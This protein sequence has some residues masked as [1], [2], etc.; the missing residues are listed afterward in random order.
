MK[1]AMLMVALLLA[2]AEQPMDLVQARL[3]RGDA[4][5]AREALAQVAEP[6]GTD[7]AAR[8]AWLDANARIAW[9]AGE[10]DRAFALGV[11]AQVLAER[12][13]VE[14][15]ALTAAFTPQRAWVDPGCGVALR[16][17]P[18]GDAGAQGGA[19][20]AA[21]LALPE[22]K[23]AGGSW[24]VCAA[25]LL[26]GSTPMPAIEKLK[27]GRETPAQSRAR[28]RV[29]L[30]RLACEARAGEAK[31]AERTLKELRELAKQSRQATPFMQWFEGELLLR[32]TAKRDPRLASLRFTQSAAAFDEAP[33]LRVAALKRAAEALNEIDPQE[34]ARLRAAADKEIP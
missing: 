21:L 17:L 25:R 15:A 29:A 34:A 5:G 4:A 19:L 2:A 10:M 12:A 20:A 13:G 1:I 3:A 26:D 24:I 27:E 18:T 22:A 8:A 14:L 30:L 9:A 7:T 6:A 23:Q 28:T 31:A 11:Q 32:D 16:V 33:W